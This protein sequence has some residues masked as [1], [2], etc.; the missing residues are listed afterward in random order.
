MRRALHLAAATLLLAS[1]STVLSFVKDSD[2]PNMMYGGTRRLVTAEREK[3]AYADFWWSFGPIRLI[4]L[5]IDFPLSVVA[6]TVLL[7][8]T[9]TWTLI[10]PDS[11]EA[12]RPKP[13]PPGE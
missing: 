13:S 10:K 3:G 4:A 2:Q 11:D 5:V 1:C 12:D 9:A 8:V 7:P 6:D